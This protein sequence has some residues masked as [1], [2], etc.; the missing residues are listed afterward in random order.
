MEEELHSPNQIMTSHNTQQHL[1][2][3][4]AHSKTGGPEVIVIYTGQSLKSNTFQHGL[5]KYF[6]EFS[7]WPS[8]KGQK[9]FV[10]NLV[11][12][13]ILFICSFTIL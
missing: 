4:H 2:P 6:F 8:I 7:K 11:L 5:K 13:N 9:K 3:S 1:A 10:E 12:H